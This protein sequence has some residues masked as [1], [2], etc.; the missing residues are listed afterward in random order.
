M[1]VRREKHTRAIAE[2]DDTLSL[3]TMHPNMCTPIKRPTLPSTVGNR[4]SPHQTNNSRVSPRALLKSDALDASR[5][6]GN[7]R[8]G[9]L[10]SARFDNDPSAGSPTET[11][12]RLLLP[13]DDQV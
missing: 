13:L 1:H 3:K 12:L 5:G 2:S 4:R 8:C 9:T 11:L 10:F 7:V 6:G